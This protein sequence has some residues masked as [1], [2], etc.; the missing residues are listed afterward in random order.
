MEAQR[1]GGDGE[2]AKGGVEGDRLS[3]GRAQAWGGEG[4]NGWRPAGWA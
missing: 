2:D 1:R 4:V 3:V